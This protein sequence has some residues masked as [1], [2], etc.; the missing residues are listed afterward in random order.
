MSEEDR[1]CLLRMRVLIQD[2]CNGWSVESCVH[3]HV[4]KSATRINLLNEENQGDSKK[5]QAVYLEIQSQFSC[6]SMMENGLYKTASTSL[7]WHV[8]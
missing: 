4:E 2:L 8:G 3:P 6:I 5:N 7:T 1:P